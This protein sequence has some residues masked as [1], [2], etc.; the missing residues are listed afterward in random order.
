M[1]DFRTYCIISRAS[2]PNNI[3]SSYKA[4]IEYNIISG[5]LLKEYLKALVNEG[6]NILEVLEVSKQLKVNYELKLEDIV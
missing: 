6:C 1:K 5:Q 4:P 2:E 3:I